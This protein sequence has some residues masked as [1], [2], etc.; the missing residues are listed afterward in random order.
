MSTAVMNMQMDL[1]SNQL[2]KQN[3]IQVDPESEIIEARMRDAEGRVIVHK[4][5]KGKLLGKVRTLHFLCRRFPI[6][7]TM[8][9]HY[10]Q[11]RVDLPNVITEYHYHQRPGML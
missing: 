9:F 4:Y 6:S 8:N 1:H 5:M 7:L 11:Y 3:D 2:D 10:L